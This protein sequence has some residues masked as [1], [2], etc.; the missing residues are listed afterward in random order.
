[1]RKIIL[2]QIVSLVL[3]TA[4][5]ASTMVEEVTYDQ[6]MGELRAAKSKTAEPEQTWG[7]SNYHLGFSM[8]QSN[9]NYQVGSISA[10]PTLNGFSITGGALLNGEGEK[11][12]LAEG[13]LK[14]FSAS[15]AAGIRANGREIAG[16]MLFTDKFNPQWNYRMGPGVAA[17]MSELESRSG[18]TSNPFSLGFV[19]E[20]SVG[21]K[22]SPQIRA[23]ASLAGRTPL[24]TGGDDKGSFDIGIGIETKL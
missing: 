8:V 3:T 16:K 12:W 10:T 1:M 22:I 20:G 7:L 17:R 11:G 13:Q 19:L 14:M 4:T 5:Y 2:L 18:G 23:A 9:T 24:L 6:L 15:E 21:Y